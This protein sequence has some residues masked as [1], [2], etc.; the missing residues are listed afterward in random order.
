M[1]GKIQQ[2]RLAQWSVKGFKADVG[3]GSFLKWP[4]RPLIARTSVL[5]IFKGGESAE[6]C[7]GNSE[8]VSPA[9]GRS[10]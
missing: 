6:I 7:S 1:V 2:L 10:R 8:A 5:F 9:A 3:F 4:T